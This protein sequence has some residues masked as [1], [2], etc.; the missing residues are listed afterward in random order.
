MR[1][2]E[3]N[4]SSQPAIPLD[5]SGFSDAQVV[6]L[7]DC[8]EITEFEHGRHDLMVWQALVDEAERRGLKGAAVEAREIIADIE[9]PPLPRVRPAPFP[10]HLPHVHTSIVGPPQP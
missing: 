8:L 2:M 4:G 7:L 9:A 10:S 3:S 1:G 5:L 6:Y